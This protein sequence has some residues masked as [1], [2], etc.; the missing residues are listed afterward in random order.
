MSEN[1]KNSLRKL[2]REAVKNIMEM[3]GDGY[4]QERP[5]TPAEEKRR[6]NW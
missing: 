4:I 1:I 2:V 6:K 5:L 3:P